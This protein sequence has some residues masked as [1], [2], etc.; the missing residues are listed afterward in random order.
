LCGTAPALQAARSDP[1]YALKGSGRGSTAG[2]RGLAVRRG[3]VVSQVALSLVLLVTALLFVRTFTNLVSVNAG[4][5]QDGVLVADFDFSPL[6]MLAAQRPEYKRELLAREVLGGSNPLG[7]TFYVARGKP[8]ERIYQI[9]GLVGNTKYRDVREQFQP[10]IFLAES[11]DAKPDADSTFVIRSGESAASLIAALKEVAE[12]TS[13]EI[14]LKFGV[15][16]TAV[17]R[18]LARGRLMAKL[19]GVY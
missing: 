3:L 14:V 15:L 12:R 10:I 4:L 5:R 11:Q 19:S 2:R 17:L 18:G 7:V 9:V 16:R 6:K 1:G 8:E 13:P